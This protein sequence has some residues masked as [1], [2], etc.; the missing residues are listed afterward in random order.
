MDEQVEQIKKA[1]RLIDSSVYAKRIATLPTDD[2]YR[3]SRVIKAMRAFYLRNN[4][5]FASGW[6]KSPE[7]IELRNARAGG[8][9][10]A[11]SSLKVFNHI[12][13]DVTERTQNIGYFISAAAWVSPMHKRV[14]KKINDLSL[15]DLQLIAVFLKA[16]HD[17]A[18]DYKEGRIR[19]G[20]TL[21]PISPRSSLI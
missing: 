11:K 14:L 16:Y 21:D 15:T 7:W 19:Q 17:E 18:P 5:P 2:V 6:S 4:K 20:R 8:H 10:S 9:S 13:N 1:K 12:F 3:A